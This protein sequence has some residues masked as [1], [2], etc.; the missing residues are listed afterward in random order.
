M[1]PRDA[2]A[3]LLKLGA[4]VLETGEAAARLRISTDAASILLRRL[5]TSGLATR[6]RK[7]MWLIGTQSVDRYAIVEALTAPMPSYISLQ[8]ALYLRGMIEQVPAVIYVVSLAKT[9]RLTTALG[10]Y[11]LHHIA[12][13][14]FDGFETRADG[15]KLATAEKALFDMAYFAGARSRLFAHVPE[16]ELP[17]GFREAKLRLWTQRIP[18]VR[19]RSMVKRRLESMLASATRSN[20]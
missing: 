6:L 10:V 2:Y 1:N 19:R 7:G 3:R 20:V 17:K 13:E 9:Q 8:T 5:A 14:L 15:S 11:S 4:P 16:L 18:A 12:P